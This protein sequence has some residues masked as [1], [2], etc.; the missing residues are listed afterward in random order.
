[1]KLVESP[2]CFFLT[3]QKSL[4]PDEWRWRANE[5]QVSLLFAIVS[6]FLRC[7]FLCEEIVRKLIIIVIIIITVIAASFSRFTILQLSVLQLSN[8]MLPFICDRSNP[9]LLSFLREKEGEG[10]RFRLH[11]SAVR[12][13]SSLPIYIDRLLLTV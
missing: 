4:H 8:L 7:L 9:F 3:F 6:F 10:I 12:I 1:M 11:R 5:R 2:S 13:Q